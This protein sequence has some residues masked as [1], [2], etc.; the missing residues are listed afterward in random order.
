[1]FMLS[2]VETSVFLKSDYLDLMSDFLSFEM[3][4]LR[5]QNE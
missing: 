3:S 2:T 1:M 5:K 4:G